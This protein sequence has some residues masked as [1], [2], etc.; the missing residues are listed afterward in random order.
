MINK[1]GQFKKIGA[2]RFPLPSSQNTSLNAKF[3]IINNLFNNNHPIGD[4]KEI[5]AKRK[6][7]SKL[8]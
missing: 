2:C 1:Q 3:S 4:Q 5:V 6:S 8:K 7:K